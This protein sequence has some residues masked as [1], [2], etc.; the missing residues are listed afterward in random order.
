MPIQILIAPR[1]LSYQLG[2]PVITALPDES[3]GR[4]H[5]AGETGQGAHQIVFGVGPDYPVERADFAEEIGF[6]A[7]T[8]DQRVNFFD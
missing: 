1:G 7:K 4:L 2:M 8:L 5:E 3:L 6:G